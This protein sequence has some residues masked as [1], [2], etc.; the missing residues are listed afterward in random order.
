MYIYT[1]QVFI[2]EQEQLVKSHCQERLFAFLYLMTLIFF[3]FGIMLSSQ[4]II[5]C[6]F[7]Y[8][9]SA[10]RE[11]TLLTRLVPVSLIHSN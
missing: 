11:H 7:L 8:P 1:K 9:L 3:T 4:L 5:L 10:F 2:V 6:L